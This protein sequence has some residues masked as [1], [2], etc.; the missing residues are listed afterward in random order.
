MKT[1]GEMHS[2]ILGS[3]LGVLLKSGGYFHYNSILSHSSYIPA[4]ESI[5]FASSGVQNITYTMALRFSLLFVCL[6]VC[7]AGSLACFCS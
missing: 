4:F 3:A 6:F 2:Q 1:D 5:D 7:F